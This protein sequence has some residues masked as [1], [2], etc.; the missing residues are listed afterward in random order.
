M[1][2]GL[3]RGE[4]PDR[5]QLVTKIKELGDEN[6][7][8]KRS[9][10]LLRTI[11][12]LID[13]LVYVKDEGG[14]Y[15]LANAAMARVLDRSVPDILGQNDAML[16][17]ADF[18]RQAMAN[19]RIVIVQNQAATFEERP[20]L[21]GVGRTFAA[22]KA[23]YQDEHGRVIGV[24]GISRDLTEQKN[25]EEALRRNQSSLA[26]A[27]R[28]AH[29]GSWNLDVASGTLIWSDEQYRI[30]GLVPGAPA[31]TLDRFQS[32]VHPEDRAR[33]QRSRDLAVGGGQ[34]YEAC[35]RLIR[36]DGTERI[37]RSWARLILDDAGRPVRMSGSVQDITEQRQ[38]DEMLRASEELFRA[39]FEGALEA[40]ILADDDGRYVNANPAACKLFG[41]PLEKLL[42][43]RLTDFTEPSFDAHE[44]WDEFRRAGSAEGRFRL[45]RP[46]GTLTYTEYGAKADVVPGRHLS[47]LRDVSDHRR[48][49]EALRRSAERLAFLHESDRAILAARSPVQI[50]HAALER[51][52]RIMRL[53]RADVGM[54]DFG[55]RQ[56]QVYAAVGGALEEFPVGTRLSL[57]EF[58]ALDLKALGQ[59]R[60]FIVD[61][62]S[63][64][65]APL[66]TRVNLPALGV[67]SYARIPLTNAGELV[68]SL[69]LYAAT[70]RAFDPDQLELA[71]EVADSLAIA[72]KQA[73]LFDE[74]R[75]GRERLQDLSRRLLW[76]QEE[77]RR[78]IAGELHDEIGQ[79]LT[80]L[81]LNLRA[82]SPSL[83]APGPIGRLDDSIAL[84][85]RTIEQVRGLSL[86]L[87]PPLLDD[88]GLVPALRSYFGTM[89]R[90]SDIETSFTV[91]DEI[92]EQNPEI[93]TACYRIAQEAMTNVVRHSG[94]KTVQ[95]ELMR[96]GQ[97]FVLVVADD[98]PGFDVTAALARASAGASL[99]LLGMR[100][101]AA[102]VG[103]HVTI[104]SGP[105]RGTI[106]RATFPLRL[107]PLEPT[108]PQP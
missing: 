40:M 4:E 88:L 41:V 21:A 59:D 6:A 79:A 70:P 17:P 32:I 77:E 103:G 28:L 60:V 105:D 8:L 52:D 12:E 5:D 106:V 78:R 66:G 107:P 69:N 91:H 67:G 22:R 9:E 3:L 44:A 89:A 74:V 20:L 68:G 27:E 36:P 51:L 84:V 13:D 55:S 87:R 82:I 54:I 86:D 83:A 94:A 75:T 31:L 34:P 101:R 100:E 92:N 7:A 19:D 53:W 48:A 23:P 29:V 16:F 49:E 85:D 11:I 93:E 108:G 63:N 64:A 43:R 26:E 50:A 72:I 25:T 15:I 71:R 47:V 81:K 30:F 95:I 33:V 1:G 99:G 35:Y 73:E 102:L 45:V 98:G 37:V 18:A 2:A 39:V 90:R 65:V 61:D 38:A 97:Q 14:R 56:A 80:A 62:T 58:G 24:A 10:A 104:A 76:A 96:S 57:D 42:D 46:D